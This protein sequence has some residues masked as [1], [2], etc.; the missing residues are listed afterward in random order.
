MKDFAVQSSSY[1][2]TICC[3]GIQ[4]Q[5]CR[6][7]STDVKAA[8]VPAPPAPVVV[9]K[10]GAGFFQRVSSFVVGAGLSALASQYYIYQE[11]VAGNEIILK[12]QKDLE[13]RL[14]KLENK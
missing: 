1:S 6:K 7:L 14:N 9:K 4:Q 11:L 2:L 5:W 8:P 12:K 13:L 3:I 10:S